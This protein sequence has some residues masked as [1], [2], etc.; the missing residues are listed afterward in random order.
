MNE[1]HYCSD[2]FLKERTIYQNVIQA[3]FASLAFGC[4]QYWRSLRH[5][6]GICKVNIVDIFAKTVNANKQIDK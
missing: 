4:I 5:F 3:S 2:I 6:W 1:Y